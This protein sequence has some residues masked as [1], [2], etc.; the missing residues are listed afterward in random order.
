MFKGRYNEQEFCLMNKK[1]AIVILAAGNSSRMG[2]AKQLLSWKNTTL[3]ENAIQQ[4][5]E[6]SHSE[7]FVVLGANDELIFDKIKKYP[8]NV[9]VHRQW[10]NGIGSSIAYGVKEIHNSSIYQ[11]V[12]L[13]LADQPN[14]TTHDVNCLLQHHI[15][16]NNK[17][18]VTVCRNYTGVPVVFEKDF[19]KELMLL[20]GDCGAKS[21]IYQHRKKVTEFVIDKKILDIDTKEDYDKM[22]K[23]LNALL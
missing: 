2:C 4:A 14:I 17:I 20:S 22:L 19:F 21:I 6:V 1:S 13:L 3:V 9:L 10:K 8:I 7:V 18:T 15:H 5:I 23:N 16:K 12:V 11:R